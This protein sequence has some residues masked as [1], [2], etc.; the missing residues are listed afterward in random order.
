MVMIVND[1]AAHQTLAVS[2]KSRSLWYE[3]S[4]DVLRKS[5]LKLPLI[6]LS[7]VDLRPQYILQKSAPEIGGINWMQ[8]SGASFSCRLHLARKTCQFMASKLMVDN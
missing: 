8:D 4:V 7:V 2:I 1:H 3:L 5:S 6:Q